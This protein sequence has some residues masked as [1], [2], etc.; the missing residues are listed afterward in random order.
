MFRE[1]NFK[2]YVPVVTFACAAMRHDVYDRFKLDEDFRE[3][4]QDTDFCLR[5]E[6]AGFR[7]LYN[8]EAEIYHLE[9]SSRDWRKG[10]EDRNMLKKEWGKK[11]RRLLQEAD[12][13]MKF[14][15]DEYKNSIIVLRDDG[16]GDLLM[17]V[18]AFKKLR[19]QIPGQKNDSW[20][21][22]S[23]MLK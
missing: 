9:C 16:I 8:P 7:I 12:Q 17:G 5:L 10:E 11:I 13:R 1:V 15:P 20:R 21:H 18:S 2:A 19:E 6:E 14:D 22:M 4:C 23:E 3:E